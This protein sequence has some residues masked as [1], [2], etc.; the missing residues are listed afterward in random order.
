M[1][2]LLLIALRNLGSHKRR[3]LLLGGAIAGV[4]ALLVILMGL[5]NG[6]QTTTVETATTLMTGHVNVSGFYKV[7]AGQSAPVVTHYPAIK[8]QLLKEVPELNYM[9]QRGRGFAKAISDT[10]STHLVLGG[11]DVQDETGFRNALRITSG[12]LEELTQPNTLL[13]FEEQAKRLDVKVG[14]TITLSAPTMRGTSNTVDV[15]VAAIAANIGMLSSIFCY[16]PNS[17]LRGLYQMRDDATGALHLYLKDTR[18]VSKVLE[19]LRKRLP[20]LQYT[21][22]EHN[23]QPFFM[24]FETVNREAWTGQR[25]D[26]TNWEDEISFITSTVQALDWLTFGLLALLLFIISV[27]VMNTLWIAIRERTREIGTLRAIGMQRGWVMTMFLLEAFMLAL[28]G[29][30]SGA[31]MG[32]AVCLG[33]NA[34]HITLPV[35]VQVIVMSEQLRFVVD[36]TAVARSITIITLCTTFV[37]LIPSYLA[38]RLKPVTA[39][40]HIG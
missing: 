38:A 36:P 21:L 32:L 16:L 11:I 7:T 27:G 5:S 28:L 17:T 23:P 30:L 31:A 2:Q 4:T 25:L 37:S 26:L 6:I 8:E 13:L 3:T 20:E 33:L 34:A 35:A 19:R 29:T 10:G 40:H 18:D 14:D 22:L 12:R 9:V 39:M 24:K 1:Q 15:R